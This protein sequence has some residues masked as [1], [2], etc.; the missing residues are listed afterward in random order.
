MEWFSLD[1]VEPEWDYRQLFYITD[2]IPGMNADASI[3]AHPLART[4]IDSPSKISYTSLITYQKGSSV[5]RMFEFVMTKESFT[6]NLKIYFQKYQYTTVETGNF[7]ETFSQTNVTGLKNTKEF[8]ESWIIK[9]GFPCLNVE[10]ID[11]KT[12]LIT[13]RRFLSSGKMLNER[14][15]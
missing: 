9:P 4:N 8:L 1:E 15:N 13:Q 2:Y 5:L 11:N 7:I 14:Y 10:K 3:T 6:Q 12:F